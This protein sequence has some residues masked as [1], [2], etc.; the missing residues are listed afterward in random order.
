LSTLP[1]EQAQVD[2]AHFGSVSVGQA[3]RR[4]LAFVVTLSHSRKIFLR[5]FFDARMA[6]FLRGHVDAFEAFG[7]VPREL[8]YDN[9]KSAVTERVGDAIRFNPTS[10]ARMSGSSRSIS[11]P[12]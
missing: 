9:L 4:L 5:F 11:S 7:G 6:S 3:T 1:G 8:L 10:A 2:W 12:W